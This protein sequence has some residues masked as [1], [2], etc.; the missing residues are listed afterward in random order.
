MAVALQFSAEDLWKEW[1]QAELVRNSVRDGKP[2]VACIEGK[3]STILQCNQHAE[4]LKPCLVRLLCANLK[5]PDIDALRA[6]VETFYAQAQKEVTT[7]LVDDAAWE[8]R[9][10]MRFVKRKAQRKDVSLD[11]LL[12]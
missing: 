12:K 2:L 1:D 11:T 4:V 7:E 9:K 6:E 8:I 3:D 10:M 5:L